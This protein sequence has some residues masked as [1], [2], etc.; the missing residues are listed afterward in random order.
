LTTLYTFC[1]QPACA[2]G[3]N[4]SAPLIQGADGNLYGTTS[5]GGTNCPLP[6][7]LTSYCGTVFEIT[8]QGALTTIYNFCPETDCT[9]GGQPEGPLVQGTDGNLYGTTSTG[10][11]DGGGTIFRLT[12][13]GELT[14]L[15][16]FDYGSFPSSFSLAV[17]QATNGDFYGATYGGGITGEAGTDCDGYCGTLYS[18]SVGLG[19]FVETLP[20]SGKVGAQIKIL[21]TDLTGATSVSFNGVEAPF[22]VISHSLIS[23]TVPEGATTGFV[24]VTT[25]AYTTLKSNARFQVRP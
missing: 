23:A 16:N 6:P 10:G 14:T 3:S 24:T 9:D 7:G 13:Q 20:T 15:Y 22:E 11:V 2:D 19:P 4:P 12:A 25:S 5:G 17:V 18:L 1:S 21:G 8:P